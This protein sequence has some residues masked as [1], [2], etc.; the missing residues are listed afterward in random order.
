M[1]FKGTE[2]KWKKWLSNGDYGVPVIGSQYGTTLFTTSQSS[3][4]SPFHYE[5]N[6]LLISKAP[7]MLDMLEELR[8]ALADGRTFGYNDY[9]RAEKLI[10]Q[11]TEI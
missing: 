3:D 2:G 5:A 9:D 4:N 1:E 8:C 7:E 11:A 10:K 6:A